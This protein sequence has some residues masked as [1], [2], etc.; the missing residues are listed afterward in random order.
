MNN[1]GH[2]II[3]TSDQPWWNLKAELHLV[4]NGPKCNWV[5]HAWI[6]SDKAKIYDET[7]TSYSKA[8]KAYTHALNEIEAIYNWKA[9]WNEKAQDAWHEYCAAL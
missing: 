8:W 3:D 7:F 9:Q 6:T 5:V 1:T 4:R 2:I